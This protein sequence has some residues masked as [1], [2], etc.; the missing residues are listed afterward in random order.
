MS[1]HEFLRD[2]YPWWAIALGL[3]PVA[4]WFIWSESRD[5]R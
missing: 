1:L 4:I 5:G 3:I 2:T